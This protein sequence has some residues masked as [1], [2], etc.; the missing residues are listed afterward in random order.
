M[1]RTSSTIGE[2]QSSVHHNEAE[3]PV[4]PAE[5]ILHLKRLLVT[6][7][8]QY[9][10]GLQEVQERLYTER[11]QRYSL[12]E[13]LKESVN[14]HDEEMGALREQQKVLHQLLKETQDEVKGYTEQSSVAVAAHFFDSIKVLETTI[15]DLK[16]EVEE[17]SQKN[18]ILKA[19]AEKF[20]RTIN[21]LKAQAEEKEVEID[22]A[23][24]SE[25]SS[26]LPFALDTIKELEGIV[27]ALRNENEEISLEN[28]RLSEEAEKNERRIEVL[29]VMAK[30]RKVE[31]DFE[32]RICYL[33]G[34]LEMQNQDLME[35]GEEYVRLADERE[36]LENH[37][38]E[39]RENLDDL[40]SRLKIAQQHL[41][42]KVKEAAILTETV[43]SQQNFLADSYQNTDRLNFELG[44]AKSSLENYQNNEMRWQEQLHEALKGTEAQVAK[45]EEKYFHMYE[46]WLESESRNKELKNFEEKHQQMQTLLAGIGNF[47]G[48]PVPKPFVPKTHEPV[49]HF[50]FD[51]NPAD[52]Q[53][54]FFGMKVEKLKPDL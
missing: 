44:E 26:V 6:L 36:S 37:I 11:F 42:K 9:E 47:M 29:E 15:K 22:L 54:D 2:S 27:H 19:E 43:A 40:E 10:K 13:Q 5:Q 35:R 52:E 38:Q 8:Q 16:E 3:H 30:E 48:P 49:Q 46:K 31:I 45:W 33:E 24:Q 14:M 32:E 39:L 18:K 25:K 4:N 53:Y 41:A 17:T 12:E 20:E 21:E 28:R 34:L 51:I 23:K 50:A 7:K 1:T